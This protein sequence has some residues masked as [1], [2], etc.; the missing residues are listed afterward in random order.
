[1]HDSMLGRLEAP[2][3]RSV[4]AEAVQV[5]PHAPPS[6]RQVRELQALRA[7]VGDA[8]REARAARD[9]AARDRAALEDAWR[10]GASGTAAA[11]AELEQAHALM[12]AMSE[13]VDPEVREI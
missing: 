5:L 10:E 7:R 6:S 2:P 9:E 12:R 8:E 1:M 4:V 13:A 3:C 11:R